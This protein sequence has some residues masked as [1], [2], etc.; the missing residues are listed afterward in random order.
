MK[1]YIQDLSFDCIIGILDFERQ[2]EQKVIVNITFDY[3]FKHNQ[4]IDYSHVANSVEKT[5]KKQKFKLIEDAIIF[6]Q[7]KLTKKFKMKN[8]VIK[9]SKPNI[10]NNC[11]V[12]VEG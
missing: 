6:L 7:N 5:M 10:L 1:V 11:I 12:S 4:F 9:I 3:N 8:L 2:S